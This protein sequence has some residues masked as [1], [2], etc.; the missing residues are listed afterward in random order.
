MLLPAD[1]CALPG[2]GEVSR[3]ALD[4]GDDTSIWSA[5]LNGAF[6]HGCSLKV[7]SISKRKL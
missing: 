6:L 1:I 2:S 7:G 4:S 5:L 3:R